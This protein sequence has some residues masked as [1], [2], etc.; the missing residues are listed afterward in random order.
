M[1]RYGYGLFV[2]NFR[3]DFGLGTETLGLIA[4]GSTASYLAATAVVPSLTA[5]GGPRLPVLLGCLLAAVGTATVGLAHAPLPLALGV[6]VA[7]A[8]PG[9]AFPPF[10][11]A[12]ARLVKPE[13][14]DRALTVISSGT[15]YGV[16]LSGPIALLA[17]GTWRVAW[18]VFAALALAALVWNSRV[19]PGASS[20]Q[21]TE[22]WLPLLLSRR[23]RGLLAAGCLSGIGIAVYFTFAVDLVVRAG[24]LPRWA[25]PALLIGVGAAG[26]VGGLAGDLVARIGL[27]RALWV[28]VAGLALSLAL[29]PLVAASLPLVLVSALLFGAGFIALTGVLVVWSVRAV[30]ER[31]DAGLAAMLFLLFVGQLVGPAVAGFVGGSYSLE[32]AFYL[33][34]GLVALIAPLAPRGASAGVDPNQQSCAAGRALRKS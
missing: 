16:L 4:T 32:P 25:G 18:L 34:A 28:T 20:G 21:A 1:A 15:S 10:S 17:G 8:S 13:R 24:S 5:R 11:Y 23:M 29:L 6:I 27:R 31:P 12:V 3:S 22:P 33:S 9:L 19:L 14:R 26:I 7:G 2:P 30:P